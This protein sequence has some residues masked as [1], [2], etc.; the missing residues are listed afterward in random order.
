MVAQGGIWGFINAAV[1]ETIGYFM[2]LREE[3]RAHAKQMQD[4]ATGYRK[5]IEAQ[6]G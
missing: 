2:R 1:A 4:M 6:L 5:L 3:A